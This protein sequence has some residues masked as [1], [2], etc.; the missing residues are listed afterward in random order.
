MQR[1][2]ALAQ[3]SHPIRDFLRP[4]VERSSP[5]RPITDFAVPFYPVPLSPAGSFSPP[6]SL[7]AARPASPAS[8]TALTPHSP[9]SSGG[10]SYPAPPTGA[11]VLAGVFTLGNA[12]VLK[13]GKWFW[14]FIADGPAV[15]V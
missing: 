7:L 1:Q 6:L 14:F 15:I 12:T 9:P 4:R 13:S 3:R 5:S 2:P 10:H 8:E 11:T